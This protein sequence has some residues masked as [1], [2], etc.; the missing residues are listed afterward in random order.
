MAVHKRQGR[1]HLPAF[2][3]ASVVLVGVT[4]AGAQVTRDRDQISREVQAT[5]QFRRALEAV[6]H[7]NCAGSL[8]LTINLRNSCTT[9]ES[10]LTTLRNEQA[11][12]CQEGKF[13]QAKS[14]D[15]TII[16]P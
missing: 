1:I 6:S 15:G 7:A 8:P 5:A 12:L 2:V 11:R 3:V 4:V 10:L 16:C 9:V 14:D 13:A